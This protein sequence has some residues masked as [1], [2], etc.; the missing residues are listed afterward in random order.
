[1]SPAVP[2]PWDP[3]M[4]V[5]RGHVSEE[6]TSALLEAACGQ[7]PR[8]PPASSASAGARGARA[9]TPGASG[10]G[11]RLGHLPAAFEPSG[12]GRG[13]DRS[14]HRGRRSPRGRR[15]RVGLPHAT[16]P[17]P[18]SSRL[19]PGVSAVLG[20]PGDLSIPRRV[21]APPQ[22]LTCTTS[23]DASGLAAST[24]Q[25]RGAK[26]AAASLPRGSGRSLPKLAAGVTSGR[27]PAA[28]VQF[29]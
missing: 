2:A 17:S 27:E 1:M 7:R 19:G 9:F 15:L 28:E 10:L 8:G 20:G 18:H 14:Q 29:V 21:S 4:R 5:K 26:R 13:S 23:L 11:G 16:S 25:S 6:E 22:G 12:T 3:A 24:W